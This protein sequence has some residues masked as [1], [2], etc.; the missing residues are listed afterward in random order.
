[1]QCAVLCCVHTAHHSPY[2]QRYSAHHM[3][4][5]A[6]SYY[7]SD[8][9]CSVA[10]LHINFFVLFFLMKIFHHSAAERIDVRIFIS[11]E[12]TALCR[13]TSHDSK[14]I[15]ENF[16]R[17]FDTSAF[18]SGYVATAVRCRVKFVHNCTVLHMS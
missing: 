9:R 7:T 15:C 13:L 16:K 14:I 1:M 3:Q 10:K 17:I 4:V 12:P 11:H 8:A 6:G 2:T 18:S 5:Y